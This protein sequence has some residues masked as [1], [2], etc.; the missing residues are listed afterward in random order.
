MMRILVTAG[1]TGGHMY[2]LIAVTSELYSKA[3]E[4][5]IPIRIRYVGAAGKEYRETLKNNSVEVRRILGSKFRRYF[6]VSNLV[7]IP[8]FG[9]SLIQALWHLFW[10]MP[11]VVFSK[12]GSGS[13]AVVLAARFYRIPVVIHET[14]SVPSLTGRVT[15]R[16]A[17]VIAVSFE[18]TRKYFADRK[19][20]EI[21]TGNPIRKGL[22]AGAMNHEEAKKALGFN[23]DL[24]LMLV[25]GGSQGAAKINDF[26]MDNLRELLPV[27]QIFHQTGRNN[28][29]QVEKE[30]SVIKEDIPEELRKKYRI[31]GYLES[32]EVATALSAAD[33]VISRSGGG[34]FEIAAFRRPS[35]LIPL[36]NSA[37]NHQLLNA[38]EYEKTGAAVVLEEANLLP[39]LF[40]EKLEE[41]YRNPSALTNMSKATKS[42]HGLDAAGNLARVILSIKSE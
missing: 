31:V 26:I 34:I 33:L 12:G 3:K 13:I 14:D 40:L 16:F 30:Y 37:G 24:P 18:S 11:D 28:Y 38:I 27:T 7:D 4:A 17:K 39:H 29:S 21:L 22:V 32:A 2:P 25:M 5:K 36:P 20:R 10:F 42:F 41:L 8:K 15:S 23:K 9:I 1:G 6:S 35:I 19:G